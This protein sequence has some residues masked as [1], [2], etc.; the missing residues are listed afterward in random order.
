MKTTIAALVGGFVLGAIFYSRGC[1]KLLNHKERK[2]RKN[3]KYVLKDMK[4]PD[5]MITSK[6]NRVFEV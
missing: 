6:I 4:V 1:S 2:Y 3:L 5:S